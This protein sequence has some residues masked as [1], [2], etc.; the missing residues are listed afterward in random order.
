VCNLE[1]PDLF[2][3]TVQD[4]LCTVESGRWGLRDPRS[5]ATSTTGMDE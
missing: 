4:F 2:N 5:L 1:E 3:H